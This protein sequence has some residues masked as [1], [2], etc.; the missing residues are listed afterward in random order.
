MRDPVT[1]LLIVLVLGVAVILFPRISRTEGEGD[2]ITGVV[3]HVVDGDSLYIEGV[4]P[5]IRLWGVDAPERDEEGYKA[6]TDALT[7]LAKGKRIICA[8]K[9]TQTT[10]G[11]LW[12]AV[13]SKTGRISARR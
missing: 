8:R 7:R 3:R 11:A 2:T 12:G 6:A 9:W 10:M 1:A 5:Q 4:E 13:R